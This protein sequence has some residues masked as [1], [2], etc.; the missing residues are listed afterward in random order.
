MHWVIQENIGH[1]EKF[2]SLIEN[3]EKFDQEY[4][5]VK[6]VP[7]VGEIIPD[8]ETS[9]KTICF[10]AYSMRKLAMKKNWT[11]GVYDM[12]WFPY[13][14][15]IDVLGDSVLNHKAVFGKFGE[16]TPALDEFFIRPTHDGK[17]FAGMIKSAGQLREWQDRV[18]NLGLS[19]NGSTLTHNTEV[20]IASLQKIYNEHRYFVIG[21]RVVTGSQYKLGKRVVYGLT[22]ENMD[23]AQKFVDK[24]S[25]YIDHPYVI[26]IAYTDDGY[27]VIE[28]NTMN[29]AGF[30]A[31]DMQKL[32]TALIEYEDED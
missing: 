8:I 5:L 3:I 9:E 18:I 22:D 16:I 14:S 25:G 2:V 1:E 13:Q 10:G 15:L 20:M 17:E 6:V 4:T 21:N 31:C 28:L 19:D 29:C 26:D 30:Y 7:F 12:D 32:V 24:L 23:V 27:K 11:P